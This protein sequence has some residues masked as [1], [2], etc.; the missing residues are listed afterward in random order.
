[1][2]YVCPKCNKKTALS[3]NECEHCG[4]KVKKCPE[5]ENIVVENAE[6]CDYCGFKFSQK[7]TTAENNKKH[8]EVSEEAKKAVKTLKQTIESSHIL[9]VLTVVSAIMG[10]AFLVIGVIVMFTAFDSTGITKLEK[11]AKMPETVS[12][13]WFFAII[14]YMILSFL[15]GFESFFTSLMLKKKIELLNFDCNAYIKSIKLVKVGGDGFYD[16]DYKLAKA[17]KHIIAPETE[18]VNLIKSV[19]YTLLE[20]TS[21]IFLDLVLM[22]NI[23]LISYLT[24]LGAESSF[25]PIIDIKLIIT[26]VL[27]VAEFIYGKFFANNLPKDIESTA[28][29][30]REYKKQNV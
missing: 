30:V 26:V 17:I 12:T 9:G 4:S 27:F 3:N 22:E 8:N 7:I 28:K 21:F 14:C 1:M 19:F 29:W 25:E 18:K 5:C 6:L 16:D 24:I 10:L 23:E 13:L 20:V 2:I 15:S 11:L